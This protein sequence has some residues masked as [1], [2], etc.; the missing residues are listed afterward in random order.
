ML[1][2]ADGR[3]AFAKAVRTS[4]G[5]A[6]PYRAEAPTAQGLSGLVPT[7]AVLFTV[8]RSGWFVVVFDAVTGHHPPLG[9]PRRPS[10]R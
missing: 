5:L 4:D 9:P 1:T 6:V 8:E 10:V 7:P 2:L 3:Q